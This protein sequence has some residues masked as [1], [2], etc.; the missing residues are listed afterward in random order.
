MAAV[1]VGGWRFDRQIHEAELFIDRHLIP[2]AHVAVERPGVFFPR[3][4][5]E[6]AGPWNRVERPGLAS[7]AD[8]K[9]LDEALGVVVRLWC[10]PFAKRG[11]DHHGVAADRG[12]GVEA[13]LSVD[14]V[15]RLAAAEHRS[16]LQIHGAVSA[17]RLDAH[18]GL[19][20]ERDEEISG[21]DVEDA[22]LF[23]IGPIGERRVPTAGAEPRPRAGLRARREPS[24]ARLSPRR[25][26]SQRAVC[27]LSYTARRRP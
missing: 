19:R 17:E 20:V 21:R 1:E 15:N 5:A 22:F 11:A 2:D 12:R 8:I 16:G 24:A 3:V 4:V 10:V 23:A 13:D 18:P 26:R 27:R 14:Q 6:L 7:R 9:R 25:A